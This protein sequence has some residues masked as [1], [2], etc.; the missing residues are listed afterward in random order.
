MKTE[1]QPYHCDGCDDFFETVVSVKVLNDFEE[2]NADYCSECLYIA[3]FDIYN[4]GFDV[5]LI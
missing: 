1:K 5:E 3:S 2:I 4:E